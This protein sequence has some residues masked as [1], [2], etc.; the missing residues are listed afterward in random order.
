MVMVVFGGISVI[1]A[2]TTSSTFSSVRGFVPVLLQP[3]RILQR[4]INVI[5]KDMILFIYAPPY[6]SE[7]LLDAAAILKFH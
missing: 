4:T 1:S 3:E 2:D 5:K 6:K 7:Y